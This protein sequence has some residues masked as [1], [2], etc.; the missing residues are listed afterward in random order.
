MNRTVMILGCVS[1]SLVA[2]A[3]I[4]WRLGTGAGTGLIPI[5]DPT[6]LMFSDQD[7][8]GAVWMEIGMVLLLLGLS[9]GAATIRYWLRNKNELKGFAGRG[10][11]IVPRT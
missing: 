3:L 2:A 7:E 8:P 5:T 9:V 10:T 11:G 4:V 1:L 6:D